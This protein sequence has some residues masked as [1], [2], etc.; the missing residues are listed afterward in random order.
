MPCV[1]RQWPVLAGI[2]TLF[3]APLPLWSL[4]LSVCGSVSGTGLSTRCV[5]HISSLSCLEMLRRHRLSS[6][7][8]GSRLCSSLSVA[9]HLHLPA[10]LLPSTFYLLP[11]LSLSPLS[12]SLS[13]SLSFS[14]STLLLSS[15]TLAPAGCM[16]TQDLAIVLSHSE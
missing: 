1:S 12:L 13:L 7:V 4:S 15:P 2:A 11:S 14:L 10:L 9:T 6:R 3:R 8:T 5:Y 16:D